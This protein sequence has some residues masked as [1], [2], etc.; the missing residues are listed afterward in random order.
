MS[1]STTF[2]F[3]ILLF[4]NSLEVNFQEMSDYLVHIG[5]TWKFLHISF[6]LCSI[7]RLLWEGQCM[8][9]LIDCPFLVAGYAQTKYAS[10][11]DWIDHGKNTKVL[12][13]H[14]ADPSSTVSNTFTLPR[15]RLKCNVKYK[16]ILP[17]RVIQFFIVLYFCLLFHF[18]WSLFFSIHIKIINRYGFYTQKSLSN[19]IVY[20]NYYK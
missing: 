11:H 10:S 17:S 8:P 20:K 15:L 13:N 5:L 4:I 6:K 1:L 2:Q 14:S 12:A 9:E 16:S 19:K 18:G 7:V 3:Q